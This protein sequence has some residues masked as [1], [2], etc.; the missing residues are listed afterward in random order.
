MTKT[1]EM[2]KLKHM[3]LPALLLLTGC[4]EEVRPAP[5][6]VEVVFSISGTETRSTDASGEGRV[7]SWTLLLYRNGKL[8]D[9]AASSPESTVIRKS[10]EA[11]GYTACAV[12]NPPESFHPE[13]YPTLQTFS[14]AESALGNNRPGRLAMAGIRNVSIPGAGAET[15]VIGVDRLVCKAVIRKISVHFDDPALAAKTFRLKALYLTNCYASSRYGNDWKQEEL[16]L[17]PERWYNRMGFT[18]DSEVDA[19]LSDR[20]IDS[21]ITP[22][23]PYGQPHTFYCCPNPVPSRDDDRSGTWSIRPTRLVI[24]AEIGGKTCYYPVTLPAMQRNRTYI[25]EEAVIRKPGSLDPEGNEPGAVETAFGTDTD[26]WGPDY[27]V[28]ETS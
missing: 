8:A 5:D 19:L 23:T 14:E 1:H 15:Q 3:L 21:I 11:G 28:E 27:P 16:S 17:S 10:L 4:R 26:D 2:K 13:D 18:S 7:D 25:I 20:G 12:V 24:E 22:A 6:T 9:A